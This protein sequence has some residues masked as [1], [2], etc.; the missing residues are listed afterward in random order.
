MQSRMGRRRQAC[1]LTQSWEP[2]GTSAVAAAAALGWGMYL[3]ERWRKAA[4]P[5]VAAANDSPSK[6]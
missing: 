6:Q 5:A 4:P 1:P 3:Y 2:H